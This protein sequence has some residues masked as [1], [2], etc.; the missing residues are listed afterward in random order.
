LALLVFIYGYAQAYYICRVDPQFVALDRKDLEMLA[1]L[2]TLP[3]DSLV[4][5][6]PMDMDNVPLVA[7]RKV[8]AN[9]ELSI[10]YHLGYYRRIRARITDMLQAYYATHWQEVE[11]FIDHYGADALV[12][13]NEHFRKKILAG[14][15]YYEPFNSVIKKGWKTGDRF[16]LANPP[17]RLRC[18]ENDR[19]IV[20]CW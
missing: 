12:V 3:K 10:P 11:T 9:R 2:S 8:L 20:L 13:R 1:F 18:F 14:S 6:H 19:Y 5:G 17:E 7:Q 15:L 16:V 4:A